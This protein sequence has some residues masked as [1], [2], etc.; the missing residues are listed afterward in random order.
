[1]QA[2]YRIKQEKNE[3]IHQQEL[4][5]KNFQMA[6]RAV[7]TYLT[8]VSEE[9]LLNE[10]GMQPLRERLLNSALQYYQEFAE[11]RADDPAQRKELAE[12][13]RRMGDIIALRSSK[14]DAEA[15]LAKAI[16][17]FEKLHEEDPND[18]MVVSGLAK[19]Y[20]T[21]SYIRFRGDQKGTGMEPAQ[22]AI[23]LLENFRKNYQ[24][25]NDYGRVLGRSYDLL[26]LSNHF[27]SQ[28]QQAIEA[29]GKGIA[30]LK[31][32]IL[33]FP[34]DRE[35]KRMLA[36]VYVNQSLSLGKMGSQQD[37][38]RALDE[39]KKILDEL[40]KRNP[41]VRRFRDDLAKAEGA[42]GR[43]FM[44]LGRLKKAEP[45]YLGP[46]GP[47]DWFEYMVK[48]NPTVTA[49]KIYLSISLGN[50]GEIRIGQGRTV[51][52]TELFIRASDLWKDD[53]WFSYRL[54]GLE[55]ATGNLP[56]AIESAEEATKAFSA[57]VKDNPED[58]EQV[59]NLQWSRQQQGFVSVAMGRTTAK[60]QI[61][62]QIQIVKERGKI[63][64]KGGTINPQWPFELADAYVRL[65]ELQLQAG[66]ASAALP[67]LEKGLVILETVTSAHE[68]NYE[69]RR[70]YGYAYGVQARIQKELGDS[71][72]ALRS[73]RQAVAIVEKLVPE[74][75]AYFYELACHR[76]LCSSLVGLGK[77][78]LTSEETAD[79]QKYES[80][81]VDAL[82]QAIAAGYDNTYKLKSDPS[83]IPVRARDD[84][85]KM[86]DELQEKL[87][88]VAK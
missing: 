70:F 19:S 39:A 67:S 46:K 72:A 63:R 32:T 83:L 49:Y 45:C 30:V 60:E 27:T 57:K 34:S 73:A 43:M 53:P 24:Q 82:R 86:L 71:A 85:K 64:D 13:Y 58:L 5:E 69:Y 59:S 62:Q 31:D 15:P 88:K 75:T 1:M 4:A 66:M 28:Y 76:A 84:F 65:S 78:E 20:Q 47:K 41:D 7:D 56:S 8:Q 6:R 2:N 79:G 18:M 42:R 50:L 25:I 17:L 68:A 38:E 48:E 36:T 12:A 51:K 16:D 21:L 80:A 26:G 23:T 3:A 54:G 52:T 14:A 33:S 35:A 77:K 11:Q 29:G 61:A 9:Q 44:D 81:S 10:P 22:K 40:V 55:A 74:E 87:S 37:Q